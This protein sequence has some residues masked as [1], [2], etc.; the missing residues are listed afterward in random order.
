MQPS[1]APAKPEDAEEIFRLC[2]E[3]ILRYEN[4]REIDLDRAVQWSH[5]KI[6]A[7]L[8]QY[9]RVML[10]GQVAGYFRLFPREGI[11]ELDDLYILPRF[12]R[13]GLGD[14]VLRHC[15]SRGEVLELYV[16]CDNHAALSLYRK[17]GFQLLRT[18]GTSR[19]VLRR[20]V[21]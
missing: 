18:E 14:A 5:R 20:E 10:D 16:F 21:L 7:H 1:F 4:P 15:V 19:C 6:L 2:R 9:T 13:K 8:D 17:H 12:Q 11:L 3:L